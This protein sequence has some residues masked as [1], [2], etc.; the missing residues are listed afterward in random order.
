MTIVYRE[1]DPISSRWTGLGRLLTAYEVDY[2]FYQIN[3]RLTAAEADI[4]TAVSISS[5]TSDGVALTV[6]LSNSSIQGPFPMPTATFRDRGDWVA[7]TVYFV[8]DTFTANGTLYRVTYAHT[9]DATSFSPTANDGAGHDYYAAMMSQ[10][11]NA[12]P[13]GGATGMM[14]KKSSG[15]DYSVSWGYPLPSGGTQ[16]QVLMK[17]SSSTQDAS[18]TTLGASHIDFTPSTASALTSDNVADALEELETLAG[19]GGGGTLSGLTDLELATGDPQ[20][21]AF[22]YY[23]VS[24]EKWFASVGNPN[25]QDI[26]QWSG[27]SWEPIP[28]SALGLAFADIT[29]SLTLPQLRFQTTT[30]LATTG[31]VALDPTLSNVFTITPTG[32]CTITA[33]SVIAGAEI[34]IIVLTSGTTSRTLTF[35]SG[36]FKSTGTLSTGTVSGKYFTIKFV[37]QTS[38]ASWWIEASRTTAM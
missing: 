5:V 9:S 36:T 15:T 21:G 6:N 3:T 17:N 22:L 29:G 26:L 31:A 19:G 25:Y 2:N 7:S 23:N 34:T 30:A 32:D 14:L 8:N 27:G 18:W 24:L 33:N 13:T 38:P 28:V 20:N 37:G 12:L 35:S 11:G 1:T 4:S 16:Y 10:P